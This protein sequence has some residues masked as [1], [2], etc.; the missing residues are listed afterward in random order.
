M[1]PEHDG[2]NGKQVHRPGPEPHEHTTSE[3]GADP[4]SGR[5]RAAAED[6]RGRHSQ[7]PSDGLAAKGRATSGGG[8]VDRH[9]TGI[10]TR[11]HSTEQGGRYRDQTTLTQDLGESNNIVDRYPERVRHMKTTLGNWIE[12][13]DRSRDGEDY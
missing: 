12:S 2:E 4:K 7:V 8:G 13:C 9:A 5:R 11:D 6:E 10:Q 1:K 3:R